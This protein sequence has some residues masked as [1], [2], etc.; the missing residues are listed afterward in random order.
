MNDGPFRCPRGFALLAVLPWLVATASLALALISW[1]GREETPTS[2]EP[3]AEG[4]SSEVKTLRLALS[5]AK[6]ENGAL[7]VELDRLLKSNFDKSG[8]GN[9]PADG[10][11]LQPGA[12]NSSEIAGQLQDLTS[13]AKEALA[14]GASGSAAE[15]I[16]AL[17]RLGPQAFP[18]LRDLYLSSTDPVA[19]RLIL[20]TLIFTGGRDQGLAFVASEL[21][22]GSDPALQGSLLL[23]ATNF[24]TPNTAPALKDQFLRALNDSAIDPS[25]RGAAVGALRYS[26][27]P[28]VTEAL[29]GAANDPSENVRLAAIE[30]LSSR[31]EARENLQQL[32]A[33]D[34]SPRVRQI[35]ECRL[36]IAGSGG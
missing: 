4:A 3:A 20:P 34:P 30:Q 28:D 18:T 31:P 32:L 5:T 36:L 12:A 11:Q 9:A 22:K 13:A 29:L 2:T 21:E 1:I 7:R 19:R 14:R 6:T 15:A 25:L 8:R 24:V 23:S 16:T 35:G 27:G 17:T 33:R 10:K 26:K